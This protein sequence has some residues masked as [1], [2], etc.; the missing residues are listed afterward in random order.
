MADTEYDVL[1]FP[2]GADCTVEP[3]HRP[4]KGG[5]CINFHP[6]RT[7]AM[8]FFPDPNIFDPPQV[9]S[10]EVKNGEHARLKI[11]NGAK[12]GVYS[13]GVH[14]KSTTSFAL[15]ASDPDIIVYG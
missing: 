13:Y 3:A 11:K 1:I 12:K 6:I 7:D 8:L 5:D 15:G 4:V 9:D 14:C 10:V 2:K